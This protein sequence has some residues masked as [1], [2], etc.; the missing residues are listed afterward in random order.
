[1]ARRVAIAELKARL[2]EY[3]AAVRSGEELVITHRGR[4]VARLAPIGGAAA[5]EGRI[6]E[7]ARSGL[8]RLPRKR[9]STKFLQTRRPSDPRGRSLEILKE[10]RSEGW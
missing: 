5:Q 3:V 6:A 2:S 4:P 8:I 10:V 1:V 9:L 7:R